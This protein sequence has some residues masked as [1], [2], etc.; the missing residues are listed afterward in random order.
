[1]VASPCDASD[2]ITGIM[3]TLY[4]DSPPLATGGLEKFWIEIGKSEK[5]SIRRGKIRTA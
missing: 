3:V 4:H 5:K 2:E 1:M